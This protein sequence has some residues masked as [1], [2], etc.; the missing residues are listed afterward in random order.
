VKVEESSDDETKTIF[1]GNLSFNADESMISEAF[2]QAGEVTAVRI[3][4]DNTG[5]KKG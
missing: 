2:S 1:V 4:S 3:I 5:R